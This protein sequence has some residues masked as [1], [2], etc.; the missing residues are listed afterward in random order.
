M[1]D[2]CKVPGDAIAAYRNYYRTHKAS[3][4]KWRL[5]GIPV[6]ML[7]NKVEFA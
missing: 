5:G 2:E 6:F 1:P 4:A 3:F 7:E